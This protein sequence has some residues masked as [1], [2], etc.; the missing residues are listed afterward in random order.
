MAKP[1]PKI[2]AS[3]EKATTSFLSHW[4]NNTPSSELKPVRS[5]ISH[6]ALIGFENSILVALNATSRQ[7][8]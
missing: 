8:V 5:E 6:M 4:A 1:A 3:E 2:L 7:P